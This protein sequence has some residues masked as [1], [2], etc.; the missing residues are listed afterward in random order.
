MQQTKLSYKINWGSSQTLVVFDR[1][2]FDFLLK[3]TTL[4]KTKSDPCCHFVS[5]TNLNELSNFS[6]VFSMARF[7]QPCKNIL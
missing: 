1:A 6:L 7:A 3:S 2:I 4:V 5:V